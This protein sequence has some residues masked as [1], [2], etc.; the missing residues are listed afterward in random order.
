MARK[1]EHALLG[2]PGFPL[3][4]FAAL[5]LGGCVFIAIAKLS[6]VSPIVGAGI[7]VCLMLFY[8]SMSVFT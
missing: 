7:P 6:G 8:L 3:V 1:H 5:T 2:H 4:V